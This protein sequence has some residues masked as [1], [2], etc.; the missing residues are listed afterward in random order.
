MTKEQQQFIINC[1]VEHMVYRLCEEE[2]M[3][4]EDAFEKVYNSTIYRILQDTG[5]GLYEQSADYLYDRL[6][7]EG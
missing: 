5:N 4:I 6:M 2:G 1:D 3:G 7:R